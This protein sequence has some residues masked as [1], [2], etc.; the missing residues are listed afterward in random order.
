MVGVI[1]GSRIEFDI[2]HYPRIRAWDSEVGHD[3]YLYLHGLVAYAHGEIDDLWTDLE[4]HHV[5]HDR[6][7]NQPENLEAREPEPHAD[8]H[9]NGGELA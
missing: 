8:Y 4:V 7:N 5:D 6:W 3:R 2:D 9:L 1:V